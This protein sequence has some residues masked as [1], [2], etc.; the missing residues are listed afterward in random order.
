MFGRGLRKTFGAS[1]KGLDHLWCRGLR[2]SKLL[3]TKD[4][5]CAIFATERI[6]DIGRYRKAHIIQF[7]HIIPT[8]V[9]GKGCDDRLK[10]AYAA[11]AG[12]TSAKPYDDV[13]TSF[14]NSIHDQLACAVARGHHWITLLWRKQR[15]SAGLG[16]L[17][18]CR[19]VLHEILRHDCPHQRVFHVDLHQLATHC[20]LKRLH[21]PFAAIAHRHLH[22]P[23]IRHL[24][25]NTFTCCLIS[26]SRC[27]ATLKRINRYDHLLHTSF[28]TLN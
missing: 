4:M 9:L 5:R 21:K 19:I 17:N 20:S 18:H 2:L 14:A 25:E 22:D 26:L 7:A 3:G 23:C 11:I 28:V 12:G 15:Q 6:G 10:H 27:Q 1:I 16:D 13:L 24:V 8:A